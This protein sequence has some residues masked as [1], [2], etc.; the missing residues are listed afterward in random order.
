M[1][2]SRPVAKSIN[3]LRPYSR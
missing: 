3:N 2:V 1:I